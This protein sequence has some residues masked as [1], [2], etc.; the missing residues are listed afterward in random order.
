MGCGWLQ[1]DG[2]NG[3][4]NQLGHRYFTEQAPRLQYNNHQNSTFTNPRVSQHRNKSAYS[5]TP[6]KYAN[7]NYCS[8]Y[9]YNIGNNHNSTY[10]FFL[11]PTYL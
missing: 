3:R 7:D 6:K 8:T 11:D 1:H 4:D 10:C 9:D 2:H 5:N